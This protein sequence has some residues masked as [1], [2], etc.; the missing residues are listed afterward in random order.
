MQCVHR[1][2]SFQKH[3]IQQEPKEVRLEESLEEHNVE[4]TNPS[5]SQENEGVGEPGAGVEAGGFCRSSGEFSRM[6]L[7]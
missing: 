7:T 2:L 3:L 5:I 1:V 4:N 6:C